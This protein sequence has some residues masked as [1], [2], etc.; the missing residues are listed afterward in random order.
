MADELQLIHESIFCYFDVGY[1]DVLKR[2]TK[3]KV[4]Y[5]RQLFHYLSRTLSNNRITYEE[6]GNYLGDI[7]TPYDH[8]T[9]MYSERKITGYLSYD[10]V[11][12]KDVDNLKNIINGRR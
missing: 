2:S 3:R 1:F 4:V 10:K 11:V 9:V 12:I 6:I 5:R 8:S 7:I